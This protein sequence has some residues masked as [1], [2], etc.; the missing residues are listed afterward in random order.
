MILVNTAPE[1]LPGAHTIESNA[2][3][4][5]Q[6]PFEAEMALLIVTALQLDMDPSAISPRDALFKEGLGLDSIDALELAL[7]ISRR[8]GVELKSDD[9][10]NGEI[11]ASLRSLCI[12][13]AFHRAA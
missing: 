8:Y 7:A 3:L 2:D 1:I 6:N 9:A 11:F 4:A 5:A 13:V 12:Y 10:R